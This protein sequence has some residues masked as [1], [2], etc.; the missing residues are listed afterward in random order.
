MLSHGRIPHP[1]QAVSG[2]GR[3]SFTQPEPED[4]AV[5]GEMVAVVSVPDHMITGGKCHLSLREQE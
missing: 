2:A 1:D 5:T 4:I 3:L